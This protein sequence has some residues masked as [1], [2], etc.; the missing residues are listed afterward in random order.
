MASC[1]RFRQLKVGKNFRSNKEK[2]KKE[3]DKEKEKEKEEEKFHTFETLLLSKVSFLLILL[4]F[5]RRA[6]KKGRK[7]KRKRKKK[8]KKKKKKRKKTKGKKG[9]ERPDKDTLICRKTFT[10]MKLKH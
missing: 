1:I 2:Q 4:P 5:G 9:K 3:K 7:R 6:R 8:R 10:K